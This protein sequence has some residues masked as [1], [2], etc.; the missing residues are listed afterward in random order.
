VAD[1]LM[2]AVVVAFFGICIAY[3][4]L[5]DRV[6]GPDPEGMGPDGAWDHHDA[7]TEVDA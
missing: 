5:C 3:V 1:L 2:V 6:I 4:S 7:A